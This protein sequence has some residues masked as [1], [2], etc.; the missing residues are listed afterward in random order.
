VF[1][2]GTDGAVFYKNQL[3]P[4]GG[5]SGWHAF[6]GATNAD[7][8]VGMDGVGRLYVFVRGT[9][10]ALYYKAQYSEGTDAQWSSWQRLG[11]ILVSKPAVVLNNEGRFEVYV[12]GT[13][14]ALHYQ[15]QLPGGWWSGWTRLGGIVQS[16]PAAAKTPNGIDVIVRT[17]DGTLSRIT[18]AFGTWGPWVNLAGPATT[19][20]PVIGTNADGRL[21]IFVRGTDG[22]IYH[23]Y[24]SAAGGSYSGFTS[25][26]GNAAADSNIGV[27]MNI[28]GR[29]EIFVRT[30]SAS[31]DHRSQ[32]SN[33]GS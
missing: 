2:Q 11:G 17:N 31:V 12:R 6:E 1:V 13:D 32:A 21:E 18:R 10:N 4:G 22:N 26:G 19:S 15:A 8:A 14:D 29:L 9:D 27:A 23:N 20:D 7:P 5:W 30:N 33:G 24:Q 28:D 3:S 16:T 25:L